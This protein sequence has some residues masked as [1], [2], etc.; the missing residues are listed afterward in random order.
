M[1]VSETRTLRFGPDEIL[2][3]VAGVAVAAAMAGAREGLFDR[4]EFIPGQQ[5]LGL[6]PKDPEQETIVIGADRLA[7]VLFAYCAV[8]RV[9]LPRLANKHIDV[10]EDHVRLTISVETEAV[11]RPKRPPPAM[12]W[13][14]GPASQRRVSDWN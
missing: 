7:V 12:E 4:V 6:V 13:A 1:A 11:V 10:F 8:L 3:A 5:S 9:P 14:P 2:K